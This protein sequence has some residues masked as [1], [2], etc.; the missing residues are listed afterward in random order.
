MMDD[1]EGMGRC[2]WR[3][4]G[5]N[6]DTLKRSLFMMGLGFSVCIAWICRIGYKSDDFHI[7]VF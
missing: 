1:L 5:G 4:F 2:A 7:P 3:C 6:G